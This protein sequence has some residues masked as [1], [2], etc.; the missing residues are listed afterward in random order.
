M[1]PGQQAYIYDLHPAN[2]R[3]SAFGIRHTASPVGHRATQHTAHS[4]QP[5]SAHCTQTQTRLRLGLG[6]QPGHRPSTLPL[7]TVLPRARAQRG[8][9][10]AVLVLVG[11]ISSASPQ[12]G[13]AKRGQEAG[14]APG[15]STPIR[16]RLPPGPAGG[17]W[18]AKRKAVNERQSQAQRNREAIAI[19]NV[20]TRLVS[21]PIFHSR[22]WVHAALPIQAHE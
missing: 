6:L 15:R 16:P 10:G 3:H 11:R 7:T 14:V 12:L 8:G 13:A 9:G 19:E 18:R 5:H 1:Y 17:P 21:L 20:C 2:P 22:T 4:T